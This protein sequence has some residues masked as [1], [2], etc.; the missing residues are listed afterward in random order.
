M[1]SSGCFQFLSRSR[2][3]NK[4]RSLRSSVLAH[5]PNPSPVSRSMMG[6]DTAA[7]GSQGLAIAQALAARRF[8]NGDEPV[9]RNSCGFC[10]L[11]R[12]WLTQKCKTKPNFLAL[13]SRQRKSEKKLSESQPQLPRILQ[14]ADPR[15]PAE[16]RS[17]PGPLP[18]TDA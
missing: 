11:A 4:H 6:S 1:Y 5:S 13:A 3:K 7:T 9:S 16:P 15:P 12:H 18:D 8:G 17:C 2:K 14:G 10:P